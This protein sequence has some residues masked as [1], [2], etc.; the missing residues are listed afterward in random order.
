[1]RA[2]HLLLRMT[3][4]PMSFPM[5]SAVVVIFGLFSA[6]E[7]SATAQSTVTP[8]STQQP[9]YTLHANK[10][11]VLTDVTVTDHKGNPIH[12]LNAS[13]FQILDNGKPQDLASFEEHAGPPIESAPPAVTKP[14]VYSNDFLLHPPPVFN[15]VLIDLATVGNLPD[16]MY[17]YY[18]LTQFL[19]HLPAG[20]PLAI[21]MRWGTNIMVLQNFT[22]DHALLLAAV[23]R[24]LPRFRSPERER[25]TEVELMHQ[26]A[27]KLSQLSGRKNVFWFCG[28]L[29]ENSFRP[30]PTQIIAYA[31]LRP[32]YDELEAGRIAVYPIDARGLM[33]SPP[34]GLTLLWSQHVL[35]NNVAEATGGHAIYDQNFLAQATN[36]LID[37]SND[38]YTLSYSPRDF[39]YD[40]SWHKVKVTLNGSSYNLSYRRGYFADGN[41]PRNKAEDL[42]S[43]GS[44]TKLLA[45]GETAEMPDVRGP[46]IVFQALVLPASGPLQAP[47]KKGTIPYTIRYS[48]PL[49]KFVM[50]NVDGKEQATMGVASMAFD[51]NGNSTAKLAQQVIAT[52]SPES[53]QTN[54]QPIYTFEQQINLKDGQNFLYLGVWDVNTGQFGAIQLSLDVAPPKRERPEAKN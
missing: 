54:G 33:V 41:D 6:F 12:G 52:F 27:L 36:H 16:Q 15:I 8:P 32:N 2:W 43:S 5:F 50:R 38:F 47:A 3:G 13:A 23:H 10:R 34:G 51:A 25:L 45:N 14:G 19:K 9:I 4:E 22:S 18:E 20:E 35:M 49:N 29:G 24:A 7:V 40:N 48:L 31:D 1:M 46:S 28:G 39:R 26:V 11:V 53:L 30:D 37:S 21:Y 17:L 42:Q 44:R